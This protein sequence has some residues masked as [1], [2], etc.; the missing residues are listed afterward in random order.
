MTDDELKALVANLAIENNKTA[1]I[2]RTMSQEADQRKQEID[3]QMQETDR[4][5]QETDRRMQETDR[6]MQETDR[7]LTSVATMIGGISKNQGDIAEEFFFNSLANDTHLGDIK[8]DDISMNPS[9]RRGQLQEEYDLLLTNGNTIGIVEVKYKLHKNDL[10]KLKRKMKNFKLLYPIYQ[11]YTVY[12]AIAAFHVNKDAKKAA[13]KQGY[14]VLQ[15]RGDLIQ[16]KSKQLV[17]Y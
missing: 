5:M 9:K 8:F 10:D 7:K 3:Q 15:R 6:Q 17:T 14:F 16:T 12:G 11:D 4:R 1:Q 2:I 13:L